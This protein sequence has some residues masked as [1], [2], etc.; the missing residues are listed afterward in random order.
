[1]LGTSNTG[2]CGRYAEEIACRYLQ[3][4]GLKLLTRNFRCLLGEVDLV[5][6]SKTHLIFIEVR[7]R[8]Y[9]SFGGPLESVNLAKQQK[10][11]QTAR[12]YLQRYQLTDRV[13]YRFDVVAL[14]GSLN[15][16]YIQWVQDAFSE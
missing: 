16:A 14:T 13:G 9:L 10:L 4:A 11:R 7:Y 5:M 3:K 1:M 2:H 15:S 8:Q 6:E 12:Y